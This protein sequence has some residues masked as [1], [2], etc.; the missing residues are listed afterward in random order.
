MAFPL[1]SEFLSWTLSDGLFSFICPCFSLL[2]HW[3]SF[4]VYILTSVKRQRFGFLLQLAAWV[5]F[6]R[7]SW[8][9]TR[10]AEFDWKPRLMCFCCHLNPHFL[11]WLIISKKFSPLLHPSLLMSRYPFSVSETELKCP[12]KGKVHYA[13][14]RMMFIFPWFVMMS[15][16]WKRCAFFFNSFSFNSDLGLFISYSLFPC[17]F[18][19][20]L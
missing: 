15:L 14:W 10:A 8:E 2:H 16:L 5:Q 17:M 20:Q 7:G 9:L 6:C 4:G 19:M 1:H 11:R 13:F 18:L 12:L 3:K